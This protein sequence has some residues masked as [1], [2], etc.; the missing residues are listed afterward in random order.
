MTLLVEHTHVQSNNDPNPNSNP[1]PNP[2]SNDEK[3]TPKTIILN[4]N[5]LPSARVQESYR[6]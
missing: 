1:N 3:I 6:A 5:L 4:L 2:N